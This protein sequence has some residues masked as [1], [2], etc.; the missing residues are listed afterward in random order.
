MQQN[1][2]QA[3]VNPS[4]CATP[5][6][7][8]HL[9]DVAWCRDTAERDTET[10][11]KSTCQKHPMVDGGCLDTGAEDD[12]ASTSEHAHSAAPIIVDGSS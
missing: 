10:K 9:T 5:M 4:H 1:T 8:G 7:V 11:D 6:W 12:D 2:Y 3:V